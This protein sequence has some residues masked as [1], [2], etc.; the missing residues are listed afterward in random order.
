MQREFNIVWKSPI[1]C[2]FQ[3]SN[4]QLKDVTDDMKLGR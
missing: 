1:G 2:M 4:L 3:E